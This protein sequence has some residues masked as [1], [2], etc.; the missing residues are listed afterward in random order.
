L[1]VIVSRML[2]FSQ[3]VVLFVGLVALF[4]AC[5]SDEKAPKGTLSEEKMATILSEIHLAEARVTR[6]QLN[7]L[8]SSLLIYSKL[9]AEIWK[10]QKVDTLVY[11]NS[12]NYYMT[13]PQQMARI[14][15]KV[16][17]KIEAREKTKNIKF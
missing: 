9:Q 10:K 12:Y 3:A 13:H 14:Y 4:S 7:S 1:G 15:E 11:K 5:E 17:K 6:L 8:D 16:T 2:S